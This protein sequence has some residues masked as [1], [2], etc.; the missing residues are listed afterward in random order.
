LGFKMM[1]PTAVIGSLIGSMVSG[2]IF[3][4]GV[5]WL[6]KRGQQHQQ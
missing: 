5:G 6:L 2:A 3:G 1:T 4:A